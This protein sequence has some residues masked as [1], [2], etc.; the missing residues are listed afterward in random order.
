MVFPRLNTPVDNNRSCH[1]SHLCHEIGRRLQSVAR[2][3]LK[4]LHAIIEGVNASDAALSLIQDNNNNGVD[5]YAT[6]PA[7]QSVLH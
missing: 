6:F 3:F 1:I 4:E 7:T 2:L 5:L